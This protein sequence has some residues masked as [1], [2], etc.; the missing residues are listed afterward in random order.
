MH[1][2]EA[3][4]RSCRSRGGISLTV[5]LTRLNVFDWCIYGSP[6]AREFGAVRLA[7]DLP[8]SALG[9]DRND[10]RPVTSICLEP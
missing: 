4:L 10:H 3:P 6:A 9:N 8:A 2:T 5:G 7:L 1:R